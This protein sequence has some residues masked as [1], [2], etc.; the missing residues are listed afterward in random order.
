MN[1][2]YDSGTVA[3]LAA[4][5][6]RGEVIESHVRGFVLRAFRDLSDE[7]MRSARWACDVDGVVHAVG[8]PFDIALSFLS[9][10]KDLGRSTL[11]TPM[12]RF[13]ALRDVPTEPQLRA[14]S[15]G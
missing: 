9:T 3:A 4:A 11:P 12:P 6:L 7:G 15:S 1:R 2:S 8:D 10:R 14:A 13:P 5:L